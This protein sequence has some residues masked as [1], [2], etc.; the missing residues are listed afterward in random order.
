MRNL[1]IPVV[2]AHG[3]SRNRPDD[4]FVP[5][6]RDNLLP[7]GSVWC[8]V[9]INWEPESDNLQRDTGIGQGSL[10]NWF[11]DVASCTSEQVL[12]LA[13]SAYSVA[14][15]CISAN[16]GDRR[17]LPILIG[18]SAGSVLLQRLA[19]KVCGL[20]PGDP[21]A[22][23][24]RVPGVYISLGSP[25]WIGRRT[26]VSAAVS[27]LLNRFI[28]ATPFDVLCGIRYTR[29]YN[30]AGI[31]DVVTGFGIVPPRNCDMHLPSISRH[32]LWQYAR[33]WSYRYALRRALKDAGW[34]D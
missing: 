2:L 18:H 31:R 17:R 28:G 20:I 32:D 5:L 15:E 8:P 12:K 7:P 6:L 13:E 30:V 16:P 21:A 3:I 29:W 23:N 1:H 19:W 34:I 4:W 26:P 33:S 14:M 9:P 22:A 25:L 24:I 27:F 10:A 11:L